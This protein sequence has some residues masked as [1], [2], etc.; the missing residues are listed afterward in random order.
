MFFGLLGKNYK[1]LK[2]VLVPSFRFMD[3]LRSLLVF[4][5]G[6]RDQFYQVSL[7]PE[8][9]GLPTCVTCLC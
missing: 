8:V 2:E 3:C 7:V 5:E 4:K 1:V 6:F 9:V